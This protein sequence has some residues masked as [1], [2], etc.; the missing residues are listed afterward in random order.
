MH[1]PVPYD[2]VKAHEYYM[3][4]RELKG[5]RKSSSPPAAVRKAARNLTVSRSSAY[6]VKVNN[7]TV[8]LTQQQLEEQ[9]AYAALRV[10]KIKSRLDELTT[11]LNGMMKKARKEKESINKKPTAADKS[12]SA[13]EAK[14]YRKEHRQE[15]ANKAK[16]ASKKSPEKKSATPRDPV[17]ELER[18]ISEVKGRLKA[19]VDRQRIL[20]SATKA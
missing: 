13:R 7:K 5:R 15:L 6:T 12:K 10:R 1:G 16:A 2:P 14:K 9:K 3:R 4:T 20:N 17:A 11:K 19:A 18:K 8:R